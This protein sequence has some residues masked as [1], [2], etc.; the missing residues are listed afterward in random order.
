MTFAAGAVIPLIVA[1]VV[2][3]AQISTFVAVMTLI[4]LMALSGLGASDI[5]VSS[6]AEETN[7][8]D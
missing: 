5:V 3:E 2:P 8:S 7:V 6:E 4:G 1:S